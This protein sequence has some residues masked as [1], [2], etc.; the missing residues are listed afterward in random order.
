MSTIPTLS[1]IHDYAIASTCLEGILVVPL[2]LI[3]LVSF[4][5]V[6]HRRDPARRPFT[7]MK[8]A[9]PF[10]ILYRR[11]SLIFRGVEY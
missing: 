9:Y 5:T 1:Q 11:I 2:G 10:I 6:R 8:A 7:W 4:F 3:W